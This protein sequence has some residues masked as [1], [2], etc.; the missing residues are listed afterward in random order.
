MNHDTGVPASQERKCGVIQTLKPLK[1][2]GFVFSDDRKTIWFKFAQLCGQYVPNIGERVSFTV[3]TDN[4]GRL[5]A[6][7]I[8]VVPSDS[9]G[10]Q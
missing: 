3:A 9:D 10:G 4:Q 8:R 1:G 6:R 2:Y 7:D 5:N